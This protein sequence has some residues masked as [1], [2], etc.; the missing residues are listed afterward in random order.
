MA[1]FTDD[2]SQQSVR[3]RDRCDFPD[4]ASTPVGTGDTRDRG[5]V[6][7]NVEGNEQQPVARVPAY[8]H[9]V[10]RLCGD[11]VREVTGAHALFKVGHEAD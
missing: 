4:D 11:D 2:R 10:P 7:S 5:A 9:D 3:S 8:D 1:S 6:P